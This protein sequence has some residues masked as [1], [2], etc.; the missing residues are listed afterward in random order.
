[1]YGRSRFYSFGVQ[2]S[3]T[4]VALPPSIVISSR[5]GQ[6][7]NAQR[8][9]DEESE[10][11]KNGGKVVSDVIDRLSFASKRDVSPAIQIFQIFFGRH[12]DEN[13][14]CSQ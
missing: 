4:K 6:R 2:V 8:D 9:V 7:V 5:H 1:M 11:N 3:G 10:K 14:H 12:D 13:A